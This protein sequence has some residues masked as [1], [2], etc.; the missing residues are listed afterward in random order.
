MPDLD[1]PRIHALRYPIHYMCWCGWEGTFREAC[2]NH[3]PMISRRLW[4]GIGLGLALTLPLVG[5]LSLAV[6]GLWRLG[7]L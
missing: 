2:P 7:T 4:V 3:P 1:I 5:L 6:W